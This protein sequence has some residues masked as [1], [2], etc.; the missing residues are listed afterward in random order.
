MQKIFKIDNTHAILKAK[1][2]SELGMM[3]PVSIKEI[4]FGKNT[5]DL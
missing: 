2:Y 4:D 3:D 1:F 5:S